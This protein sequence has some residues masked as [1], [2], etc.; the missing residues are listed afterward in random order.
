MVVNVSEAKLAFS[1][2]S[3]SCVTSSD[4]VF[5]SLFDF[6]CCFSSWSSFS[7]EDERCQHFAGRCVQLF[8]CVV[9]FSLS[10]LIIWREWRSQQM[11]PALSRSDSACAWRTFWVRSRA[12]RAQQPRRRTQIS[13]SSPR[14]SS[15]ARLDEVKAKC[16]H[17]TSSLTARSSMRSRNLRRVLLIHNYSSF[18]VRRRPR[19]KTPF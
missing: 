8:P 3:H 15:T 10:W 9:S 12:K 1:G 4:D 16:A 14:A 5:S 17:A 13:T 2:F 6:L 18:Y 19:D 7:S 11:W